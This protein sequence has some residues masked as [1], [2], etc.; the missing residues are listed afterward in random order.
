MTINIKGNLLNFSVPKIM[1]ILNVTP[2]S[3]FDGGKYSTSDKILKQVEKMI[4]S[5]ADIIDIGGYSSRPGATDIGVDEELKRV[6]PIVKL[7]RK[8][9]PSALISI[10]TFR[11]K[12]AYESIITGGDIINDISGGNLDPK[13][14][15]TVANLKVP[16]I[17]MH[18]KGNP[19]NM[20]ENSNYYDV[21]NE[22][23]KYFSEKIEEARLEGI[24]DLIID[25]GF[26]FSKT[27]EQNYELLNNLDFLKQFQKPLL[28]GVSR[29]SMIYKILNSTPE[30]ALNG[31]SILHTVS[32]LKGADILRTHDVKE[33]AECI[34]IIGQLKS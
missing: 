25:P 24:N 7:I 32:L 28:V 29:K 4:N 10:D 19:R 5:G 1:G 13:M 18:M 31:T 14:F 8:Q 15:K 17:L 12:V 3:F 30:K 26:G 16:Y 20:T 21:T 27:T 9:F 11:S 6:I 34:K 23:C 33:A 22:I 2:D